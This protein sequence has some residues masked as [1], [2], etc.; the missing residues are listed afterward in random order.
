MRPVQAAALWQLVVDQETGERSPAAPSM[1]PRMVPP[2]RILHKTIRRWAR[3]SR[4]LQHRDRTD[5]EFVNTLT[6]VW[7]SGRR[8]S[9]SR[10]FSSSRPF[11]PH[12]AEELWQRFFG[13]EKISPMRLAD[14][15]RGSLR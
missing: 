4:W 15:W 5:A 12:L 14:V 7:P 1:D 9:S 2:L 10:S 3:T 11:A 6:P 8:R 13:H